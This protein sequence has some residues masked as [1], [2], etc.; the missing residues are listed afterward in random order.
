MKFPD[1]IGTGTYALCR[2][3]DTILFSSCRPF[4]NLISN[5]IVAMLYILIMKN[6]KIYE[7]DYKTIFLQAC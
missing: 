7:T 2:S 3:T 5:V 1:L 4:N 6:L